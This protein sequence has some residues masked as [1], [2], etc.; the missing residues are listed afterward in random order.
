MEYIFGLLLNSDQ[1]YLNVYAS[2]GR[3]GR[4]NP[5]I[6]HLTFLF[7][8]SKNNSKYQTSSDNF[9]VK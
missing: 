2:L 6:H 8:I 1:N 3:I 9:G 4:H 7:E 5:I